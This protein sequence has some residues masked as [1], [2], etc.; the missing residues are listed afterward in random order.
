[1]SDAELFDISDVEYDWKHDRSGLRITLILT[2]QDRFNLLKTYLA[3]K[4]LVEKIEIEIGIMDAA[5][6]EQ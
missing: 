5:P 4:S 6:E 3:L 1:M 2:S